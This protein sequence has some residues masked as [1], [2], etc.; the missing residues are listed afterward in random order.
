[1]NPTVGLLYIHFKN[2]AHVP[3]SLIPRHPQKKRPFRTPPLESCGDSIS[4]AALRRSAGISPGSSMY[5][6]HISCFA[7]KHKK[8]DVSTPWHALQRP[9]FH[10]VPPLH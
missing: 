4:L 2:P 9:S 7:T 6:K 10:Y 3:Y 8:G 5:L 1:M